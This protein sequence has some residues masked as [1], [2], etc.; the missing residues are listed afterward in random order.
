MAKTVGMH[1]VNGVR[2][3]LI[4]TAEVVPGVSGG[5][6]ALIVG[7]YE[8]LITSA[9]HAVSGVRMAAADLVRGRGLRR[10]GGEFAKADWGAVIAVLIGMVCAVA[11]AATF[12]APVVEREQQRS[13]AFFFGLV[14]A[15]LWVPYRGSGRAWKAGHYLLALAAGAGAFVLTGLPPAHLDPN[16]L[17]VMAAAAVAICALVLPGVSGSFILLTIGLYSSTMGAVHDRDLGYLGTFMVGAVIGLAFFVK[18]LQLLLD[19]YHH[20]TL[21]VLTGLMAGSLR[22]L[23]PWQEEDRTLLAPEGDVW[24]TTALM[25]LGFAA[26]VAVMLAERAVRDRRGHDGPSPGEQGPVHAGGPA[27]RL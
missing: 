18:L 24:W 7:I 15:S 5:T 1:I 10:A 23:W 21:V 19:R 11:V 16:P 27:E 3:A 8:T 22:A 6:V 25:A 12:L 9:G 4:G 14:L 13:Y 2:G 20:M 17:V 26:V